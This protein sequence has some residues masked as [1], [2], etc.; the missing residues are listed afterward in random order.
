MMG[1]G[2]TKRVAVVKPRVGMAQPERVVITGK[3]LGIGS[4]S[5]KESSG[6]KGSILRPSICFTFTAAAQRELM[7][8]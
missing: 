1:Q 3:T 5:L 4:T 2:D 6:G 8:I 7:K